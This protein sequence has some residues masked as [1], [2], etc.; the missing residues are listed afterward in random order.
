M[1]IITT[2]VLVA[3]KMMQES[4]VIVIRDGHG[5]S[6]RTTHLISRRHLFVKMRCTYAK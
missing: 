3:A 6:D 5:I 4:V 2:H 1:S